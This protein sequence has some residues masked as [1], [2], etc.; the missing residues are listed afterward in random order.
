[1]NLNL[2][3]L[4]VVLSFSTQAKSDPHMCLLLKEAGLLDYAQR[5]G[6][7]RGLVIDRE[8]VLNG[9]NSSRDNHRYLVVSKGESPESYSG[10]NFLYGARFD[11]LDDTIDFQINKTPKKSKGERIYKN[12]TI[13]MGPSAQVIP[14]YGSSTVAALPEWFRH[15][16]LEPEEFGTI[17]ETQKQLLERE[18]PTAE[19]LRLEGHSFVSLPELPNQRN[20]EGIILYRIPIRKPVQLKKLEIAELKIKK[21]LFRGVGIKAFD[22]Y[23]FDTVEKQVEVEFKSPDSLNVSSKGLINLLAGSLRN[24]GQAPYIVLD[25]RRANVAEVE[26]IRAVSKLLGMIRENWHSGWGDRIYELR[27]IGNGFDHFFQFFNIMSA[28]PVQAG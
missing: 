16:Y 10:P 23:R 11:R 1:M 17:D 19:F 22:I 25:L 3:A 21:N 14:E 5:G 4:I 28:K 12:W 7:K 26:S 13:W 6:D 9:E 27:V 24:G 18:K 2:F 20:P 8:P 15:R